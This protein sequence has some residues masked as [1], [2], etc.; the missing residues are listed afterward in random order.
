[1]GL[2]SIKILLIAPDSLDVSS[3]DDL[4]KLTRF[5]GC[6]P[7]VLPLDYKSSGAEYFFKRKESK[8]LKIFHFDHKKWVMK[9]IHNPF[10]ISHNSKATRSAFS[11]VR[12]L[13][14]QRLRSMQ[15]RKNTLL[16][17]IIK[18]SKCQSVNAKSLNP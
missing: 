9:C 13:T 11:H 6:V 8:L 3:C 17:K 4:P 7:F 18:G 15:Y 2:L 1:M 5:A 10:F 12:Y 16:F 14:A